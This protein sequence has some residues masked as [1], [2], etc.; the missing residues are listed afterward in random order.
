MLVQI[1]LLILVIFFLVNFNLRLLSRALLRLLKSGSR[2]V[3]WLSFLFLPGT[4]LH[5]VGHLIFAEFLFVKTD[6]LNIIPEVKSDG[7]VKLGGV[8]IEQT[9]KLRRT[10]I[11]LA[12]V[13]FGLLIIWVATFYLE[14]AAFSKYYP[15]VYI[16]LV[17]QISHTMFASKK[18]LE[19]AIWGLLGLFILAY[20]GSYLNEVIIFP[21]FRNMVES[22]VRFWQANLSY[23]RDGLLYAVLVDSTF[24]VFIWL[25]NRV[26]L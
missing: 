10:I 25:V 11:G 26:I 8:K 23:L 15:L 19:G 3:A 6:D 14:R 18:D 20:I 1:A 4:F 16:Y 2:V 13:L 21:A 7:S 9:D 24:S 12:P 22:V 17:F 5:E